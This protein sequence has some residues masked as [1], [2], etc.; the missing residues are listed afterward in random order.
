MRNKDTEG[1]RPVSGLAALAASGLALAI[2]AAARGGDS[3]LVLPDLNQT[4]YL[5]GP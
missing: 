1:R 2:P 3:D 4:K 5:G